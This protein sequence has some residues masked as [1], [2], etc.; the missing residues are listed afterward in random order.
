MT[1]N[2]TVTVGQSSRQ[3]SD[4]LAGTAA[5]IL[6]ELIANL[7]GRFPANSLVAVIQTIDERA[8]DFWVA[9]AAITIP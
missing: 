1:A 5:R 2:A 8:H 4:N 6:A 3:G 7:V 9:D